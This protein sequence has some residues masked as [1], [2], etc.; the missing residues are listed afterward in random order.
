MKRLLP[1]FRECGCLGGRAHQHPRG[2]GGGHF[3]QERCNR[4]REWSGHLGAASPHEGFTTLW[5]ASDLLPWR[6]DPQ[7]SPSL[8]ARAPHPFHSSPLLLAHSPKQKQSLGLS[9]KHRFHDKS[10]HTDEKV[11]GYEVGPEGVTECP[12]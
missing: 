3:R 4:Q 8:T 12:T 11:C 5:R 1:G 7:S 9:C 10:C 2:Q 6:S